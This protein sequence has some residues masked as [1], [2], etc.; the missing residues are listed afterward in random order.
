MVVTDKMPIAEIE[1]GE[2]RFVQIDVSYTDDRNSEEWRVDRAVLLES[3]V[4]MEEGDGSRAFLPYA[5]I[6]EMNWWEV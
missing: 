1:S 4:W 2:D 5:N 6:A 3:G